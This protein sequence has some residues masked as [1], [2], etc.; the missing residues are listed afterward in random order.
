[1]TGSPSILTSAYVLVAH[2]CRN[3][4]ATQLR[5]RWGAVS[6]KDVRAIAEEALS[7]DD[8]WYRFRDRRRR[9]DEIHAL[10][11]AYLAAEARL[12]RL[13][14]LIEAARIIDRTTPTG[15]M[16]V[17]GNAIFD[18]REAIRA[19]DALAATEEGAEE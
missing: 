5:G 7:E 15:V 2:E 6:A 12:A 3:G 17:G 4:E 8:G 18:L 14:P 9:T 10:A 16:V 11:R 13:E 19:Y 1:M